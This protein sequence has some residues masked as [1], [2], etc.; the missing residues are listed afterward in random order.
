MRLKVNG[1]KLYELLAEKAISQRELA[2]RMDMTVQNLNRL[3]HKDFKYN[4]TETL[5]KIAQALEVPITAFTE[6]V[7]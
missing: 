6:K 1:E 3:L 5:G 7:K 4:N 2:R